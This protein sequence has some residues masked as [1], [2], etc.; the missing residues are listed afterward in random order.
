MPTGNHLRMKN[1][2]HILY[3]LFL[4]S[5]IML[6]VPAIPHHHHGNGVICMKHD[7]TPEAECPT[8][9]HSGND[10]CCSDE[11][12]TRFDSPTPA[13]QADNGPQYIFV[14]TLF[15]GFI[16][17]NLFKPQEQRI[18]NYYAYRESLHGTHV[19]RTNSLRAPPSAAV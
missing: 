19:P 14:A 7:V 13:G 15:T 16:I 6:A 10:N 17:E 12:L 5:M 18:K 9:H 1:K 8:H 4:V 2:R 3:F 11:C